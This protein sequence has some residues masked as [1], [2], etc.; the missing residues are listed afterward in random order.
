[1]LVQLTRWFWGSARF[2]VEGSAE[3]FFNHCA[4]RGITLWGMQAGESPEAWVRAGQYPELL[5][6][7][8]SARSVSYTHLTLPAARRGETWTAVPYLVASPEKGSG[9]WSVPRRVD[10]VRALA[11]D[12]VRA[13]RGS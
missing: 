11:A 3:R 2:R 13:G 9:V 4:R 6:C 1:M 12:L 7:A 8:H 5:A 10:F